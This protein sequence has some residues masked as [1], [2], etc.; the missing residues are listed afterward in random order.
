MSFKD[1]MVAAVK[2]WPLQIGRSQYPFALTPT[3]LP[4]STT[5]S[6]QLVVPANGNLNVGVQVPNDCDLEIDQWTWSGTNAGYPNTS[7]VTVQMYWGNREVMLCQSALP[8][9]C[10]FGTAQRPGT[11]GFRPWRVAGVSAGRSA[12][13]GFATFGLDL[14]NTTATTTTHY[15]ALLGWRTAPQAAHIAGNTAGR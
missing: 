13:P 4:G 7:G 6:A 10:I 14:T 9:E 15:L 8:L 11:F 2:A 1:I 5:G 3:L 12:T